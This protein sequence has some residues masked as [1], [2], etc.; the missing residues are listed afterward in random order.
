M[1]SSRCDG[2][3]NCVKPNRST[4]VTRTAPRESRVPASSPTITSRSSDQRLVPLLATRIS[5]GA[6]IRADQDTLGL[7]EGRKINS[8]TVLRFFLYELLQCN[9]ILAAEASRFGSRLW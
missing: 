6:D 1:T 8:M 3:M 5:Y 7:D 2:G 9:L 4:P